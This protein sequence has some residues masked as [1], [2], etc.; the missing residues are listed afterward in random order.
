MNRYDVGTDFRGS[1]GR[2]VEGRCQAFFM[3]GCKRKMMLGSTMVELLLCKTKG[4]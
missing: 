1:I 4:R 2:R 3:G